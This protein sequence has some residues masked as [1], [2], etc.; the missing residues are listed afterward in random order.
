MQEMI[1]AI[2]RDTGF[3]A[4]ALVEARLRKKF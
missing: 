3:D 1:D 4:T 2:A